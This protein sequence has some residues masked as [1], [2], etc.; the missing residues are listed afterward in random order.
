MDNKV[1]YLNQIIE[2]IDNKATVFKKNKK[3]MPTAA[4]ESEKAILVRTINDAI[5]LA[6]EIKP[7]PFSLINDLRSLIKQL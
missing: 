1:E 7:T 3:S 4:Y 6:E 5:K 2:I